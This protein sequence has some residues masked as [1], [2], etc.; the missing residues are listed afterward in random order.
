MY[1]KKPLKN[2]G[3]HVLE[4]I[5]INSK[6]VTLTIDS[7][8]YTISLSSYLNYYLYKDKSLTQEEISSIQKDAY[9]KKGIDYLSY[10][11]NYKL[12]SPSILKSK[13]YSK[14]FSNEEVD[15]LFSH[16]IRT[17]TYSLDTYLQQAMSSFLQKGYS[18]S[19]ILQTLLK[20]GFNQEDI[21][22]SYNRHLADKLDFDIYI[23]S[24]FEK[25]KGNSFNSMKEKI[26]NKFYL[27]GY[28]KSEFEEIFSK[29]ISNNE[30]LID[31]TN[32]SESKKLENELVK[33]YNRYV[34][35][36]SDSYKLKNKCISSLLSKGYK[37]EMIVD[38]YKR[39]I[40]C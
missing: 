31:K 19:K 11:V 33:I 35:T 20:E 17:N 22:N 6:E 38:A 27:L 34:N 30:E 21:F 18:Y 15:Y 16:A 4:N 23:R 7:T 12:Y 29:F 13:L 8:D 28:S 9:F 37:Y 36:I 40:K 5:S 24:L 1:M 2:T 14:G 26:Y 25:Y 3:N 32:E 39:C 10:L